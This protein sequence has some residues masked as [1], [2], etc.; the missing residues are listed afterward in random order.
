MNWHS[1]EGA[2]SPLGVTWIAEEDAF[3]FAIYSKHASEVTLL[4][5]AKDDVIHPVY[6]YKLN[7]LINKSG[8]I[9]HCRVKS[10]L[11]SGARYYAYRVS[12]P[13]EAGAGHRFDDQKV[14]V[15]PYARCVH[16]PEGFSRE[17]ARLPGSNA[18]RAP[19]GLIEGD[20]PFRWTHPSPPIHTFDLVIY[21]LHVRA[22]TARENS[23]VEPAK[24]GTFA[25]LVEK[26]PYLV[27]L[28]ITAVELMPVVQQDPQEGSSWGYMPLAFFA[29][30]RNYASSP[31]IAEM[32]DEFRG[33]IDAF[34]AAGIE[35]LLDVVY[36]HTTEEG[37]TGPIYNFKGIDNS[38][39][40]LLQPGWRH[41]R[42]D[43]GTGNTLN[44]ANHYVRRMIVDAL[45]YWAREMHVDGFRFDLASI[46]TRQ[47]DGSINLNDPPILSAVNG[48]MEFSRVRLIAEAWD[49]V[50]YQQGRTFPGISW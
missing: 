4:L 8:R 7:P 41:Y 42:D 14:L 30:H 45:N 3:N 44:C 35:V 20:I 39:Y 18:G 33:M 50:S 40:Y 16:F 37:E 24:R 36:N 1:H 27:D 11:L 17:V 19:L 2:A 10:S 47:E 15:D 38:T 5:Y 21:E 25:G 12:G 48:A 6:E 9:W 23:G 46:F 49:P 29:L 31:D 22:F 28:G 13:N 34:H 26:I 43:T 32:L